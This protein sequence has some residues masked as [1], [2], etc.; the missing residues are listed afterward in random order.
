MRN[1]PTRAS[2]EA[3]PGNGPNEPQL[4]LHLVET[5][6]EKWQGM[7]LLSFKKFPIPRSDL[8]GKGTPGRKGIAYAAFNGGHAIVKILHKQPAVR[9]DVI[10]KAANKP[11]RTVK[12]QNSVKTG[13]IIRTQ[14]LG[15][16]VEEASNVSE[17]LECLPVVT[18]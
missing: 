2:I 18:R 9:P 6:V 7:R 5:S 16:R 8:I 4:M 14:I 13:I 12:L 15:G 1:D 11:P 17:V 3:L 10:S